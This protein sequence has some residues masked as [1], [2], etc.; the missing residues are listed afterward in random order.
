MSAAASFC[1]S[2]PTNLSGL[3]MRCE[4][5]N[6]SFAGRLR[7]Q[8][9][10][11]LLQRALPAAPAT[12]QFLW[13]NLHQSLIWQSTVWAIRD[14]DHDWQTVPQL[15]Q[16]ANCGIKLYLVRCFSPKLIV[17]SEG[18]NLWTPLF[19]STHGSPFWSHCNPQPLRV[20]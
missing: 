8:I 12:T 16:K 11:G 13:M 19:T 7:L 18:L 4:I 2:Q 20:T 15:G 17:D 6:A 3:L 9:L 10:Q 14:S 5:S 1:W